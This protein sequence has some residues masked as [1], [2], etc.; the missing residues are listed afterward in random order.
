M[1]NLYKQFRSMRKPNNI[2]GD[3]HINYTITNHRWF[4]C[5]VWIVFET[6]NISKILTHLIGKY[7][8]AK[9]GKWRTYNVLKYLRLSNTKR[10]NLEI[11]QFVI[12]YAANVLFISSKIWNWENIC[13]LNGKKQDRCFTTQIESKLQSMLY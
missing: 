5:R 4:S 10:D 8:T 13:N 1:E 9:I 11:I 3:I 12:I 7:K 2:V 6:I